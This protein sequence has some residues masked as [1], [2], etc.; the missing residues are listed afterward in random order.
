MRTV[1][2]AILSGSRCSPTRLAALGNSRVFE[3]KKITF[4]KTNTVFLKIVKI[5]QPVAHPH[6]CFSIVCCSSNLCLP[7]LLLLR[8]HC[9]YCCVGV[10]LSPTR[11]PCFYVSLTLSDLVNSVENLHSEILGMCVSVSSAPHVSLRHSAPF[12]VCAPHRKCLFH[13]DALQTS[14]RQRLSVLSTQL[15]S[16]LTVHAHY[17]LPG[18]KAL[19]KL[20]DV[21]GR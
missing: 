13:C 19:R 12:C 6:S 20:I 14:R 16:L 3:N 18:V 15:Q 2:R 17:L 10:S 21:E 7:L 1:S 8:V 11:P 4:L 9:T 5:L